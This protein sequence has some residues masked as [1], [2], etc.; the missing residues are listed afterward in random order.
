MA[1]LNRK[2][3]WEGQELFKHDGRFIFFVQRVSSE[4]QIIADFET[5]EMEEVE[6]QDYESATPEELEEIT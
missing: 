1:Q 4:S 5:G 6:G 2:T 3:Q